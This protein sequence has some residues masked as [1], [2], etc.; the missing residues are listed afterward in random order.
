MGHQTDQ[1]NALML[2]PQMCEYRPL[3]YPTQAASSVSKS[4][5]L[6]PP[7]YF[8]LLVESGRR[9]AKQR[10]AFIPWSTS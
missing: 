8:K 4:S 5:D 6:Q 10:N 2:Y 7:F 1:T 3:L 9:L